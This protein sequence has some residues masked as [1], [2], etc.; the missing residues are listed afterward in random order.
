[1]TKQ[2]CIIDAPVFGTLRALIEWPRGLL[3]SEGVQNLAC[4]FVTLNWRKKQCQLGCHAAFASLY[5]PQRSARLSWGPYGLISFYLSKLL[6]HINFHFN[7]SMR[8]CGSSNNMNDKKKNPITSRLHISYWLVVFSWLNYA[9][10]IQ[11]LYFSPVTHGR[12]IPWYRPNA[13]MGP[14]LGIY[15]TALNFRLCVWKASKMLNK[16]FSYNFL[17]DLSEGTS[18][19]LTVKLV[20]GNGDI[21]GG[22]LVQGH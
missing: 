21:E 7:R 15:G 13:F 4:R 5:L 2:C 12:V 9:F 20:K 1:M 11:V 22:W 10:L 18:N 6:L 14:C 8:N 16:R 3:T 17:H 19:L